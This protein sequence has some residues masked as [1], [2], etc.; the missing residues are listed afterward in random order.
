MY[1]K[2]T[3]IDSSQP[4]TDEKKRTATLEKRKF[5]FLYLFLSLF[6]IPLDFVSQPYHWTNRN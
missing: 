4:L 2:T 5:S 6:L 3:F 1:L